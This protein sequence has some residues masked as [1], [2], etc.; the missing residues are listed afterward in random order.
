MLELELYDKHHDVLMYKYHTPELN[1]VVSQGKA[2]QNIAICTM[3]GT[4]SYTRLSSKFTPL[5]IEQTKNSLH[6][7]KGKEILSA[8]FTGDVYNTYI[9]AFGP[10]L[11]KLERALQ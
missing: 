5:I 6:L 10:K 3:A 4:I 8:I 7:R 11:T 2:I 1:I 9:T